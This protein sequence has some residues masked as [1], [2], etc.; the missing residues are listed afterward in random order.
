MLHWI[1]CNIRISICNQ[2]LFKETG[3]KSNFMCGDLLYRLKKIVGTNYFSVQ[4]IK[5]IFHYKKTGIATNCL[6]VNPI[7][8]GSFTPLLNCMSAGWHFMCFE[9]KFLP[10]HHPCLSEF[11]LTY[12]LREKGQYSLFLSLLS[13]QMAVIYTHQQFKI[14]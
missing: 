12:I 7:T 8:V 13:P 14:I 5:I 9:F 3:S 4:F 11:N 2:I 10:F 1:L 6:V